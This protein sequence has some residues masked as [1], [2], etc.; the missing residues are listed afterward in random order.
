MCLLEALI[1]WYFFPQGQNFKY[2]YQKN[3]AWIYP[4]LYAPFDFGIQKTQEQ[5]LREKQQISDTSKMYFRKDFAVAEEVLQE[6]KQKTSQGVFLSAPENLRKS[7]VEK[8]N[9]F[10]KEIYAKGV[11]Q[12]I[13]NQKVIFCIEENNAVRKIPLE[14]LYSI[15]TLNNDINSYFSQSPYKEY[16]SDFYDVIINVVKPDIKIDDYFSQKELEQNIQQISHSKGVIKKG[17]LIIAQNEIVTPQKFAVISSLEH[18]FKN[19][20]NFSFFSSFGFIFLILVLFL[21]I[22]LYIKAFYKKIYENDANFTL[23]FWNIF[24]ICGFIILALNFNPILIYAV[25][26]CGLSVVFS[27]FFETRLAIFLQY[28]IILITGLFVPNGF[29]FV[30]ISSLASAGIVLNSRLLHFRVSLYLKV[31]HAV[32]MYLLSYVLYEFFTQD[33]FSTI[34]WEIPSMFIINGFLLLLAQPL[35]YAYE[36]TFGL[37]SNSS[38]LELSSTNSKLMRELSE[39]APGTFQHTMQV[40]ILAEAAA[41]EIGANAMLVR[42]GAMYHDIGKLKNPFYF[43][44]NQTTSVN[45]HDYLTPLESAKI[46]INH[47]IDGIELARENKIPEKIIDF[48]RTH[49]GTSLVY[50]FYKKQL[51]SGEY[52]FEDDFKYL[53]PIPFSKETAILMMADSVEAAAKSIKNPTP[54]KF[55]TLI[56]SIFKRQMDE[57][58]FINADI[59]LKEIEKIKKI[60]LEKLISIYKLRIEYPE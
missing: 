54:D 24:S 2:E 17:E 48:I 55:Q 28:I 10:L 52:F 16:L 36:R 6:F 30:I 1:L 49:H 19:K 50:Y 41:I 4:T 45:P 31:L 8:S 5:I 7:F 22:N 26:I 46:I 13:E 23:I 32:L 29:Q 53:G 38:L 57:K 60:L 37:I 43:T 56:E 9:Q 33:T 44:E 14:N 34:S 35:I 12:N 59:T 11:L 15:S 40:A 18:N 27:A 58:Q 51:D 47:A 21:I 25:P 20:T 42:A 3:K 39:K